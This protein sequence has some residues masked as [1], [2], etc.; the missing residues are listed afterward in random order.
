MLSKPVGPG[1]DATYLVPANGDSR[2]RYGNWRLVYKNTTFTALMF[3]NIGNLFYRCLGRFLLEGYNF[4]FITCSFVYVSSILAM[5]LVLTLFFLSLVFFI[6]GC[7]V[8]V[9][10]EEKGRKMGFRM[11]VLAFVLF[12]IALLMYGHYREELWDGIDNHYNP[13]R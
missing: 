13:L 6:P 10:S 2:L 7:L 4:Y 9:V 3:V 11:I 5:G 1:R 8:V 12:C